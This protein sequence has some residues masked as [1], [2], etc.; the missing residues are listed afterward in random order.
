MFDGLSKFATT[1]GA[2]ISSAVEKLKGINISIKLDSTNVNV[3]LNDGGLLKALTGEVQTKI[4]ES[5]ESQ[6]RVVEG[7]K[8]KRDSKVLGNR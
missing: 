8:L 6:F 7:G 5:I 2:E 1:F 3:N 4:F